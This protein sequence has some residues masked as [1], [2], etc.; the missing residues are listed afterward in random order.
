MIID[1]VI[2][3]KSVC[4]IAKILY[5]ICYLFERCFVHLLM[6]IKLIYHVRVVPCPSMGVYLYRYN[7]NKEVMISKRNII[8]KY[9][10]IAIT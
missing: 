8:G 9:I 3:I 6:L 5:K 7:G 4:C 2:V 1:I 10:H